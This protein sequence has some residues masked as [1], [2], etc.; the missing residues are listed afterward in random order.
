MAQIE[1][2]HIGCTGEE[3][4]GKINEIVAAVNSLRN[5]SSYNDLA[6]LPVVNGVELR[7]EMSTSDLEIRLADAADFEEVSGAFATRDYVDNADTQ[8]VEAA[9]SAA[10][11][12][13]DSK[14]DKDLG[15]ITFVTA[16]G[17]EAYLPVVTDNGLRKVKVESL[18]NN[19][20]VR[21]VNIDSL[22][23][24]VDDQLTEI[25]LEG[26]QDGENRNFSPSSPFVA[27]TS[28]LFLNGQRLVA[29]VDYSENGGRSITLLNNAPE[30]SDNLTF[31]AVKK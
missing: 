18:A 4:V 7:G 16:V 8:T 11:E 25:E 3:L 12:V 22:A 24:A 13:L 30:A 26:E 2:L 19:V 6:D 27:G 5:V 17:E 21:N 14:M 23:K 10:Q 9:A 28:H 29:G 15:N 20:A 31:I 1:L